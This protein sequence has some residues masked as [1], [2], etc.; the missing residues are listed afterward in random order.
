MPCDSLLPVPFHNVLSNSIF[1]FFC[2]GDV[3]VTFT[4]ENG[5]EELLREFGEERLVRA[6]AFPDSPDFLDHRQQAEQID[7]ACQCT[8]GGSAVRWAAC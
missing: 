2:R 4:S 3:P 1:V 7:S 5:C 6:L 8:K